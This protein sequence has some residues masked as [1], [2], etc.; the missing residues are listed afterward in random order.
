MSEEQEELDMKFA[1]LLHERRKMAESGFP[2]APEVVD[3]L[4][5][6]WDRVLVIQGRT[7]QDLSGRVLSILGPKF[8]I[9]KDGNA[10]F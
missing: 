3:I 8:L 9:D 1:V 2:G 6:L 5:D 10:T 7:A 4:E